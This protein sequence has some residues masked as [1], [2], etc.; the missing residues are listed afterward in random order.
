MLIMLYSIQLYFSGLKLEIPLLNLEAS[1][2]KFYGFKKMNS[3]NI[4]ATLK[5]DPEAQ[6]RLQ[7]GLSPFRNVVRSDSPGKPYFDS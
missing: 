3:A 5:E 6:M 2:H 4:Q 1:H 7:T